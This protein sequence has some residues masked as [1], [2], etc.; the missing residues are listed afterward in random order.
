M[1][2]R[3]TLTEKLLCLVIVGLLAVVIAGCTT[4]K[5]KPPTAPVPLPANWKATNIKSPLAP[6]GWLATF[7]DPLLDS[8]IHGVFAD[9]Y[10]LKAASARMQ[11][12]TA[13]SRATAANLYPQVGLSGGASVNDAPLY[14]GNNLQ[15]QLTPGNW[16]YTVNLR[17]AWELDVWGR[18]RSLTQA[19]KADAATATFAYEGARLSLAAQGAK[20]WF[21]V[22]ESREQIR[23]AEA[24]L[25]SLRKTRVLAL[26]RYQNG[27]VS[28]FDVHLSKAD[29]TSAESN[30]VQRR[31]NFADAKRS[32]ETL[33]GRYPSAELESGHAALPQVIAQVPAGLPSEL[34]LRRPDLRAADWRLFA[35]ENR[36]FSARTERLPRL[37]L[38]STAGTPSVLLQNL[39]SDQNFLY[40][41]AANLTEPILDGGRISA[42]IQLAKA[43]RDVDS[44]LYAQQVLTAFREVENALSNEATLLARLL[45]QQRAL[46]ELREAY[47]IANVRYKSGQI[48]IVSLLQAQRSMLAAESVLVNTQLLRI[49][50][51]LDLYL[52]L[53]ES[54]GARTPAMQ[55]RDSALKLPLPRA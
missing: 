20:A 28:S 14:N 12:A 44:A 39:T 36:V 17:M 24:T 13:L 6:S 50:N 54:V 4:P 45:L 15:Y 35:S 11:S 1:P 18:L 25:E 43:Q 16:N 27:A 29:E 9:N 30:L 37:A 23:I 47:R 33:L 32:L 52:A 48:D 22:I 10:D 46:G 21:A 19:S 41:V 40:T 26:A 31:Q 42:N 7:R 5:K 8:V 2:L 55:F 38:T 51:R 3:Q 53:G 34:L 49:N